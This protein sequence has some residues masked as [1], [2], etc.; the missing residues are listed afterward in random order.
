VKVNWNPGNSTASGGLSS[1]T[2]GVQDS[3]HDVLKVL[4]VSIV[5]VQINRYSKIGLFVRFVL[6]IT[7]RFVIRGA[8]AHSIL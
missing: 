4:N 7:L 6:N 3:S 2:N 5:G 8:N 1:G